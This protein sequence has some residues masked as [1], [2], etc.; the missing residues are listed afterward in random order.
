MKHTLTQHH[1]QLIL[2]FVKF[3]H[4]G[5]THL[6]YIKGGFA[7]QTIHPD[8]K[9]ESFRT[10]NI[11]IE[12]ILIKDDCNVPNVVYTN[13]KKLIQQM[14]SV[15]TSVRLDL[16][17][18]PGV[19]KKTGCFDGGP[20]SELI[21]QGFSYTITYEKLIGSRGKSSTVRDLL[22]YISLYNYGNNFD[23]NQFEN[24]YLNKNT[25]SLN[26]RGL[27]V[28]DIFMNIDRDDKGI[29]IDLERREWL[30]SRYFNKPELFLQQIKTFRDIYKR[31]TPN[32]YR[33]YIINTF[34]IRYVERFHSTHIPSAEYLIVEYLRSYM[35]GIISEI[36]TRLKENQIDALCFIVGG[37]AV[38]R[39]LSNVINTQDIDT[40]LYYRYKK[41]RTKCIYI[42]VSIISKYITSLYETVSLNSRFRYIQQHT[43]WPLDL[44]TWDVRT[45]HP[46]TDPLQPGYQSLKLDTAILDVAIQHRPLK[47]KFSSLCKITSSNVA[48]ANK[49]FLLDDLKKTYADDRLKQKRQ[50]QGKEQKN[51]KRFSNLSKLQNDSFK[52][53]ELNTVT[54]AINNHMYIPYEKSIVDQM[55]NYKESTIT[56]LKSLYKSNYKYKSQFINKYTTNKKK[57]KR[58]V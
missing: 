51:I 7:W 8:N 2:N 21:R 5:P 39:Y 40:K 33:P 11:D 10:S 56:S 46:F 50:K 26:E 25:M 53:L 12:C 36:N 32:V 14:R 1:I 49:K 3:I 9:S 41:D 19:S 48:I 43:D 29:N 34:Y 42:V 54:Y 13:L 18:S 35:N 6:A 28:H 31:A 17:V 27:L 44:C 23:I 16:V 24:A 15:D 55:L 22:V 57:R 4:K 37:D 30:M 20:Y 52:H 45:Q 58:N 47:Q 38:R